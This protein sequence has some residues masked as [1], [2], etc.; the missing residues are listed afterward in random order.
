MQPPKCPACACDFSPTAGVVTRCPGCELALDKQS[1]VACRYDLKGTPLDGACSECGLAVLSTL[2]VASM[3]TSDAAWV[4]RL[5]AGA[6]WAAAA[7]AIGAAGGML[8]LLGM[9]GTI[10]YE[11]DI[12]AWW[13]N[14]GMGCAVLIVGM[15]GVSVMRAGVLLATPDPLL[16]LRRTPG[17]VARSLR[18][19]SVA[20]FVLCLL[21]VL[22]L[23]SVLLD[24]LAGGHLRSMYPT[25]SGALGVTLVVIVLLGPLSMLLRFGYAIKHMHTLSRRANGADAGIE[26][27]FVGFLTP[28]FVAAGFFGAGGSKGWSFIACFLGFG[29]H[30]LAWAKIASDL[31]REAARAEQFAKHLA[32]DTTASV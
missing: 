13:G 5:L 18:W 14:V 15:L 26:A 11:S 29:V 32:R 19:L 16:P 30:A 12:P 6:R 9:K 4:K 2:R 21:C 3:A 20:V 8:L 17:H 22:L 23:T 7:P 1:C 25:A 27:F 24:S 28:I 31:A 10:A